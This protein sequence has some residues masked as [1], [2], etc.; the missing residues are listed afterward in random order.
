[1]MDVSTELAELDSV[2]LLSEG[3]SKYITEIRS[4]NGGI[5]VRYDFP[6]GYGASVVRHSVSYGNEIGLFELAILDSSGS[7]C[8]STEITD[9]V[10]GYLTPVDVDKLLIRI[11]NL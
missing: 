2:E 6:N 10:I 3:T 9:D 7:L 1:M 5:Q 4:L 11:K 8:Y